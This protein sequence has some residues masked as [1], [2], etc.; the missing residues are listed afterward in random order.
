M[1]DGFEIGHSNLEFEDLSMGSVHGR[2]FP[3]DNYQKVQS[4]FRLFARNQY[5]EYFNLRDTLKLELFDENLIL[6][7]TNTIHIADFSEEF[8][9]EEIALEVILLDGSSWGK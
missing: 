9:P 3:T 7:G 2:F 1:A 4:I 6:I 5:Q 8:G